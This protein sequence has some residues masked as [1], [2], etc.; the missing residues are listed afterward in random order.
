[1]LNCTALMS[2]TVLHCP[3]AQHLIVF[4]HSTPPKNQLCTIEY[5]LKHA[6]SFKNTTTVKPSQHISAYIQWFHILPEQHQKYLGKTVDI[7]SLLL[8]DHC[9][10]PVNQIQC[11]A[12]I[13]KTVLKLAGMEQRV[14]VS[15]PVHKIV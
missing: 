11:K 5:F 10:I 2:I 14:I 7:W 1:M 6:I 13:V 9:Y 3:S 12:A 15:V 8:S 4:M